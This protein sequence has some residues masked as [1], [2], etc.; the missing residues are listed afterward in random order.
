MR[1]AAQDDTTDWRL[2]PDEDREPHYCIQTADGQLLADVF[3]GPRDA[4]IMAAATELYYACKRAEKLLNGDVGPR[5]S[6]RRVA[7]A[8]RRA[9][10]TADLPAPSLE[11]EDDDAP[12][13]EQP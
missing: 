9:I 1:D 6:G 3:A 7:V 11:P 13:C 2:M 10:E 12:D 5:E 8:L 4:S